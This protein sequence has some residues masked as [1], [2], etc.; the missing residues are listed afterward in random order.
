MDRSKLAAGAARL[1]V[2]GL[3][4]VITA[5]CAMVPPGAAAADGIDWK[6]GVALSRQLR[7]GIGVTWPDNPL[8]DTIRR[9][10][11][12]QQVAM[13]LARNVDPHAKIT[14][15]ENGATLEQTLDRLAER[16]GLACCFIGPVAYFAPPSTVA[17]ALLAG[18]RDE[19]AKRLPAA[20]AA[21]LAQR[22][23]ASW[24]VLAEPRELVAQTAEEYGLR[25]E[26]LERIPH[27]LWPAADLPPLTAAERLS[28]LLSGFGLTFEWSTDGSAIRLLDVDPE[29]AVS[30]NY[31]T[32]GD[33][34]RALA[35]LRRAVPGVDV[36]RTTG[37]LRV[38]AKLADHVAVD[39]AL[40]G[41]GMIG[42]GAPAVS[43]PPAVGATTY[44]LEIQNKPAS[45]V[46]AAVAQRQG[47]ELSVADDA[48][49]LLREFVSFKVVDVSLDELLAKTLDPVGLAWRVA[50]GKLY[51]SR[52]Q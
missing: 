19:E 48:Q 9:L 5:L 24:E 32:G 27:D 30:R 3:I 13:L 46:V 39:R 33:A 25:V 34:A 2:I 10:S 40:R 43:Q 20:I 15:S 21:R 8:R 31:E 1:N 4:A 28:L 16:G 23:A 18:V 42:G 52:K 22:R 26:G 45:A 14:V 44:S 11:E 51:I 35:D 12:D 36:Q 29:A 17:A 6:T 47:W 37:G 49:P 38:T 7:A 50:D 41:V